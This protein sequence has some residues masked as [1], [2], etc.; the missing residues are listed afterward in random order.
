MVYLWKD[1]TFAVQLKDWYDGIHEFTLDRHGDEA[2][3]T[4]ATIA[5]QGV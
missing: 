2:S 5:A 4:L 3:S 1:V